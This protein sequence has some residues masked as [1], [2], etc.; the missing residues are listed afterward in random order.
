VPLAGSVSFTAP[1][2]PPEPEPTSS[3]AA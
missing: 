3:P 2:T 1:P